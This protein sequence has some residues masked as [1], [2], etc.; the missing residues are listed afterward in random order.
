MR[1][2]SSRL[3]TRAHLKD[4]EGS[5]EGLEPALAR[6]SNPEIGDLGAASMN[7]IGH[8]YVASRVRPEVGFALGAMLPDF[9]GMAGVRETSVSSAAPVV[10]D[11]LAF[12]H[13]VDRVFHTHPTFTE[14]TQR[15]ERGLQQRGVRF[16]VSLA[17]AHVGLELLLD[18]F[19]LERQPLSELYVDALAAASPDRLGAFLRFESTRDRDRVRRLI[20][21]LGERGVPTWYGDPATVADRLVDI[22]RPYPD[23]AIAPEERAPIGRYLSEMQSEVEPNVD[24]LAHHDYPARP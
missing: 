10:A 12:H 7:F 1:R 24:R 19:L 13:A 2:W 23:L 6:R 3:A 21:E 17:V 4:H 20:G 15:F 8:A 22:L 18:G 16:S 11:G 9:V 5:I 14:L